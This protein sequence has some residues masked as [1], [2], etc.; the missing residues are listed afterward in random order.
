MFVRIRQT[1]RKLQFTVAETRRVDG[2][3]RHEHVASLG[4]IGIPQ[5]VAARIAF[6]AALYGRLAKLG[7]RID[8]ETQAK[9]LGAIHAKVPMVTPDEQRGL[10]I[11]NAEADER[12]WSGLRDVHADQI[13]GHKAL[14]AK[15]Q[16]T[17]ASATSEMTHAG[18]KA[19]VAKERIE[20]L[21]NGENL[22]GGLSKSTTGFEKILRDAG[23]TKADLRHARELAELSKRGLFEVFIEQ[24]REPS[25]KVAER[26][27]HKVVRDLLKL[28]DHLGAEKPGYAGTIAVIP[29]P[30]P[31]FPKD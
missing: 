31:A 14:V 8:P 3:V 5:T 21:K 13:E 17:I 4:S 10:Q 22:S 23:W 30:I 15:A 25:Q 24:V 18:Q 28:A 1:K 27:E 2:K 6:W 26:F 20:K 9:I 7:N 29:Q 11:E 16:T 19:A 12:L